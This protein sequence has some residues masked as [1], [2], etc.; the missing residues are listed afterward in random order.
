MT[1]PLTDHMTKFVTLDGDAP[2][3]IIQRFK[4]QK[5]RKKTVLLEAGNPCRNVFFVA[6]GC[7]RLYFLK[8]NG[9]EQTTHFALENWWLSDYNAFYAQEVA[10]FSIDA[11]EASEILSIDFQE[12]EKLL[13]DYPVLEKYFRLIHQKANAAAQ[14]RIRF[15]YEMS[16]EDM[17]LQFVSKYPQFCQRVPQYLLASF[18]GITPEYLSEIRR[19][20]LPKPA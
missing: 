20:A 15:L 11:V 10:G 2:A 5:V 17:Y 7:L 4:Q 19:K 9:T 13:T 14:N 6:K 16:R 8:E 12:M 1:S 3:E 18:L